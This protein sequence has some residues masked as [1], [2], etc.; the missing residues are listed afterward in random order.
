MLDS[1]S[2]IV[3]WVNSIEDLVPNAVDAARE[4]YQLFIDQLE[5]NNTVLETIKELYTL[6]G[7]TYKT[8]DG[9]N[10][11][12]KVGQERLEAQ[13]AQSELQKAWYDE[14]RIRLEE[15]QA[16]LDSL[17]GDETDIRYDTY[18]KARDAYL[19]EFNEAEEAYL[20]LAKDAMETA[21]EIYEEQ[22]EK[23]VYDF[24]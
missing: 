24:G 1:A 20:S 16:R 9:F 11:L 4:R 12:Q 17:G 10:R 14:A 6:Q 2:A 13:L 5:H 3:E 21:Q 7:V 15:A 23:A 8:M 18:K 22:L 19:A